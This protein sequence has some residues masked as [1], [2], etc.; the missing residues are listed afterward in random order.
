MLADFW[1]TRI[2]ISFRKVQF[3]V[4]SPRATL[5]HQDEHRVFEISLFLRSY[6]CN[7]GLRYQL[8]RSPAV[9]DQTRRRFKPEMMSNR[10]A[11]GQRKCMKLAT[12]REDKTAPNNAGLQ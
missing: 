1:P 7:G 9:G 8:P 5:T 6:L 10:R 12:A 4:A 11:A 2:P 3:P